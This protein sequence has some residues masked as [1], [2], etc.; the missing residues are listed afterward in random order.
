MNLKRKLDKISYLKLRR[1]EVVKSKKVKSKEE[2]LKKEVS[3]RKQESSSSSSGSSESDE[4]EDE[5]NKSFKKLKAKESEKGNETEPKEDIGK[6]GN[7]VLKGDDSLWK[8]N[9]DKAIV[10]D[11]S[12]A[13]EADFEDYLEDLLL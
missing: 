5:K 3:K 12:K 8:N 10:N 4:S 9:P 6:D 1:K 11:D 13:R 2:D 7:I